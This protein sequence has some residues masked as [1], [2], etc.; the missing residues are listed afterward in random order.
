MP[1]SCVECPHSTHCVSLWTR[2]P[3][4]QDTSEYGSHWHHPNVDVASFIGMLLLALL[5]ISWF[6][7]ECLKSRKCVLPLNYFYITHNWQ[8]QHQLTQ[9]LK[10]KLHKLWDMMRMRVPNIYFCSVKWRHAPMKD[11]SAWKVVLFFLW[12]D[13]NF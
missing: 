12:K 13:M 9:R 2:V 1:C 8:L 11:A 3:I 10:I 5:V 7:V 6:H 4:D